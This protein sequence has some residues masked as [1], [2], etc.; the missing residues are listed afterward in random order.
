MPTVCAAPSSAGLNHKTQRA[1]ECVVSAVSPGGGDG[2]GGA[3][4]LDLGWGRGSPSWRPRKAQPPPGRARSSQLR[5]AARERAL[6][7]ARGHSPFCRRLRMREP[8]PTA[9]SCPRRGR[10]LSTGTVREGRRRQGSSCKTGG[11]LRR[12]PL[13]PRCA[14]LPAQ[15]GQGPCVLQVTATAH[16]AGDARGK[17]VEGLAEGVA[18]GSILPAGQA[19]RPPPPGPREAALGANPCAL[20]AG[21][22]KTQAREV[23]MRLGPS[24]ARRATPPARGDPALTSAQPG[25]PGHFPEATISY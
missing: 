1:G 5:G 12:P 20:R 7:V 11:D 2:C 9:S 13:P 3:G 4:A 17:P 23:G 15:S 19:P 10:A 25:T 24:A 21:A 18:P 16:P 8:V 22:G 6:R 14:P